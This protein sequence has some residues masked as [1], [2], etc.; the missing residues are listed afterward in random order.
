MTPCRLA[1]SASVD[2]SAPI[3]VAAGWSTLLPS[4]VKL[5]DLDLCS[6]N[7]PLVRPPASRAAHTASTTGRRRR[8]GGDGIRRWD[9][10]GQ[11]SSAGRR[12]SSVA[13]GGSG[14]GAGEG[15]AGAS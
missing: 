12:Y 5:I 11:S 2:F 15:Y 14:Y 9:A 8:R 1:T 7:Q 3:R 10:G 13:G 6:A 4:N